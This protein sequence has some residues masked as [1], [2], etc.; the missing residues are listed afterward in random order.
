VSQ[1]EFATFPT[2]IHACSVAA[3]FL[4]TFAAGIVDGWLQAQTF[5]GT[6]LV[7]GEHS[8]DRGITFVVSHANRQ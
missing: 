6:A 4:S 8:I 2:A 5:R 7:K 1:H 3:L